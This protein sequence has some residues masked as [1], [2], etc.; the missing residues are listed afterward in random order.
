MKN[1]QGIQFGLIDITTDQF[2]TL[3]SNHEPGN[4]DFDIKFD[5]K[6][7]LS[8]N[9]HIVG[10]YTKYQFE[11]KEKMVLVIEC[12]CH[13]KLDESYWTEH[14]EGNMLTLEEGLLTHLIVLTVGTSRGVLHAKK[15][16]W[17]ENLLLPT[18]NVTSIVT[19]DMEFDLDAEDDEEE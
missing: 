13:F 2:A 11:Q 5:V 14:T 3:E 8:R 6:F 19:E 16:K 4:M 15:P 7:R 12:G 18:I 17:L 9:Q 1:K 10:V